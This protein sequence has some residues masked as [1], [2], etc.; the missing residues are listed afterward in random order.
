MRIKVPKVRIDPSII[1][2]V[3]HLHRR[4][5]VICTVEP[6]PK[7]R[8]LLGIERHTPA[9]QSSHVIHYVTGAKISF[10]ATYDKRCRHSKGTMLCK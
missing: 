4:D 6:L 9:Y 8:V 10:A 3:I 2:I 1:C 5:N 7:F